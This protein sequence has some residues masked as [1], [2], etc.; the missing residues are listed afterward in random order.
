MFI[1]FL[2]TEFFYGDHFTIILK[3]TKRRLFEKVSLEF[4]DL[5]LAIIP[6]LLNSVFRLVV[7]NVI[8][9]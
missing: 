2:V 5:S 7:N 3:V 6:V 1:V 8:L 4:C 9:K